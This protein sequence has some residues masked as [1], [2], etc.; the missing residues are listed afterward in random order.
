MK[1][2][3]PRFL[4]L[5][6]RLSRRLRRI[7]QWIYRRLFRWLESMTKRQL[8][9]LQ[10]ISLS[11][12]LLHSR[13]PSSNH[14]NRQSLQDTEAKLDTLLLRIPLALD[15][16]EDVQNLEDLQVLCRK[17]ASRLEPPRRS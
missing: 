13:N 9:M 11:R 7:R 12:K 8:R 3:K 15:T 14:S 5:R 16:P 2:S 17:L 1:A 4:S 6:R 10:E